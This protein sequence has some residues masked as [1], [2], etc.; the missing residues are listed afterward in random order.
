LLCSV[1]ISYTRWLSKFA[2]EEHKPDGLTVIARG[3]L[4]KSGLGSSQSRA[5]IYTLDRILKNRPL[6]H[7]WGIGK[8]TEAKLRLLGIRTLVE[9][10]DYPVSRLRHV[11]GVNGYYL[12]A[13]LNGIEI[14][15]LIDYRNVRSKSIGHSYCLPKKTTNINYLKTVMMKLCAKT[16]MRLRARGVRASVV[17]AGYSFLKKG[18]V[19]RSW[20][21]ARPIF[22]TRDIYQ[23]ASKLLTAKLVTAKVRM[24]AVSVASFVPHTNQLVLFEEQET[25]KKTLVEAIDR[26]NNTFASF[27]IV[28]G[29]MLYLKDSAVDRIGFRKSVKPEE[30]RDNLKY[31]AETGGIDDAA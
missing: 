18:G 13:H 21:L 8:R 24:L 29:S 20:K 14:G 16:G 1:G 28:P 31:I 6:Q 7:A 4:C 15:G 11:L 5:H 30:Q 27:A 2:S 23:Q 19:W 10:K 17:Y 9:L 3:V 26:I 22:D 12:W 25:A